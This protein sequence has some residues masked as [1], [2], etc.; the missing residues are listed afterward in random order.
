MT[1]SNFSSVL[2]LVVR[3]L[4]L[5]M[6]IPSC[7]LFQKKITHE[8]MQK[9]DSPD[10]FSQ[11]EEEDIN[12]FNEELQINEP[13]LIEDSSENDEG[14]KMPEKK[15]ACD[16]KMAPGNKMAHTSRFFEAMEKLDEESG[17]L[18]LS[19]N[20]R[21]FTNEDSRY[22]DHKYSTP[23]KSASDKVAPKEMPTSSF[24]LVNEKSTKQGNTSKV[25]DTVE[26]SIATSN[27]KSKKITIPDSDDDLSKSEVSTEVKKKLTKKITDYFSKK[28]S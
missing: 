21:D 6:Y 13:I 17:Q 24:S 20:T 18:N 5:F 19:R 16:N 10:L 12:T 4:L 3:N 22:F 7:H 15:M 1:I 25:L 23:I 2:S 8:T 27:S 11:D 26:N 14:N 9:N 28:S